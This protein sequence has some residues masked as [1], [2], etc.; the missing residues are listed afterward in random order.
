[1]KRTALLIALVLINP[2]ELLA[3]EIAA[4]FEPANVSQE[5]LVRAKQAYST[6]AEKKQLFDLVKEKFV[7]SLPITFKDT[8]LSK[9]I[10]LDLSSEQKSK[11]IHDSFGAHVTSD[12]H[13][14]KWFVS[15]NIF[16][17]TRCPTS[18]QELQ[19]NGCKKVQLI[20]N[21]DQNG[22]IVITK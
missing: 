6:A 21:V 3:Y 17:I 10:T 9:T 15:G 4:S 13:K 5:V 16:M 2:S 18:E 20:V 14:Y 12:A 1:M 19:A 11:E 22:N 7:A 8:D